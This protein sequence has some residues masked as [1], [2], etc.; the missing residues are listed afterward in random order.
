MIVLVKYLQDIQ[1]IKK[2]FTLFEQNCKKR[3]EK[4]VKVAQQLG[5]M[6]TMTNPVKKWFRN[7]ITMPLF[8]KRGLKPGDWI[9]S[10]NVDWDG[11]TSPLI[12]GINCFLE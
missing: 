8:I 4:I 2:A 6:F 12:S 5:D 7:K 9:Y 11:K 1:D 10:Y 3:A